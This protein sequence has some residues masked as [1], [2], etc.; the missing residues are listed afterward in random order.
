MLEDV[1]ESCEI[2]TQGKFSVQLI[3]TLR[4]AL[5]AALKYMHIHVLKRKALKMQKQ[6][7]DNIRRMVLEKNIY[8]SC[9][10]KHYSFDSQNLGDHAKALSSS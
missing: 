5:N 1:S 7:K 3:K 2:I 6:L 10:K 9:G 4:T 8:K